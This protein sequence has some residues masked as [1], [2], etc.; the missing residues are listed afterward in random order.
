MLSNRVKKRGKNLSFS[1]CN[2]LSCR[3][4]TGMCPRKRAHPIC[5]RKFLFNSSKLCVYV[6]LMGEEAEN[7]ENNHKVELFIFRFAEIENFSKLN[8]FYLRSFHLTSF[9]TFFYLFL[10]QIE[11]S[12]AHHFGFFF[13]LSDEFSQRG[14]F[15]SNN[16]P[17]TTMIE[18]LDFDSRSQLFPP[19]FWLAWKVNKRKS[20]SSYSVVAQFNPIQSLLALRSM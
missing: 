14:T 18:K 13:L 20:S 16:P 8:K 5:Y 19:I 9:S 12:L 4:I 1:M 11:F 6:H 15:L 3:I 17:S 10:Q 2:L 7:L